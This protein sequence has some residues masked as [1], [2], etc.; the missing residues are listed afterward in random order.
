M[1]NVLFNRIFSPRKIYPIKTCSNSPYKISRLFN[2]Q[3][4]LNYNAKTLYPILYNNLFYIFLRLNT[5]KICGPS[6][7]YQPDNMI[8]MLYIL[9]NVY[10]IWCKIYIT[11]VWKAK[12]FTIDGPSILDIRSTQI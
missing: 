4:H 6:S 11:K 1:N 5:Y 2:I 8:Y 9:Y 12:A 10:Y 3:G 7:I